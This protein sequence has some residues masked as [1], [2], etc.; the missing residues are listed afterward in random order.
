MCLSRI[1]PKIRRR[2]GV[3]YK[4]V[5]KVN[6]VYKCY[7]YMPSAGTVKYPLN[8]WVADP[9]T[10][11]ADAWGSMKTYPTGFHI[12]LRREA[13]VS[14][15]CSETGEVIIRVKFRKVVAS[16]ID[17]PDGMYGP[18]VVAREIMNLGELNEY[19]HNRIR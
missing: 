2:S 12:C 6:G 19:L 1:D 10:G 13:V 18:Q 17:N 16:Q 4:S 8:K 15:P 14:L 5:R 3:G 11:N 9:K 7:D